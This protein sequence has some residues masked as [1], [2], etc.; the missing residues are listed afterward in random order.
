MVRAVSQPAE[1]FQVFAELYEQAMKKMPEGGNAMVV[2]TVD[3]R[4]RPSAR[5]CL[6]KELDERG[7]VFYTN[8]ESRKGRELARAPWACLVFWWPFMEKQVR[9]D[10]RTERVTDAEADAYFATRPRGSQIGAWASLQSRELPSRDELDRRVAELEKKYEGK[11]VPRPPHWSGTRV[12]PDQ[13]EF[14]TGKPSRL[15]ER[16]V[17]RLDGGKWTRALLY[18]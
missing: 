5:V 11:L 4:G 9:I 17:Y 2:S 18:P 3:E 10:G 7:F 13:M 16:I 15:H 12:I 6:L 14:W 8:L 1:P